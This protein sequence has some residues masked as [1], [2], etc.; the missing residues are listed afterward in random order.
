MK[1]LGARCI[2]KE[3]KLPEATKSG[4]VIPGQEKMQTNRGIVIAIGDGAMLD[5][6]T[7]VPMQVKPG[8]EVVYAQFAGSPIEGK[9]KEIYL[10]LNER[11]IL[12]VFE[13]DEEE[14]TE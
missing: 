3:I 8:D 10:V 5:N 11:D 13:K 14:K 12:C 1:V 2:V 6:G 4:I 9:D 7:K